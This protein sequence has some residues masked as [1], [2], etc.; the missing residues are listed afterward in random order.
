MTPAAREHDEC[1]RELEQLARTGQ[2]S[3]AREAY[4][5]DRINE[6]WAQMTSNE[7]ALVNMREGE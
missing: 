2:L 6:C 5:I 7:R 3:E 4:L 1:V